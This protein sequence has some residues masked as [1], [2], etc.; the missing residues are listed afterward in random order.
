[1]SANRRGIVLL[2]VCTAVS[3]AML[4]AHTARDAAPPRFDRL[5]PV[6]ALPGTDQ[7]VAEKLRDLVNERIGAFI[8]A[9]D[10]ANVAGFYRLRGFAPLW[11]GSGTSS[12][13][14]MAAM[15]Y[16]ATVDREG[17]DPSDYR[18]PEIPAA[19]DPGALA[20][21]EIRFTAAILNY[22]HEAQNGRIAFSHVTAD[23]D[24]ARK[25]V[26]ARAVLLRIAGTENVAAVLASFN[27]PQPAYRALRAR[28]A[29]LRA[30]RREEGANDDRPESA[31]SSRSRLEDIVVANMERWRWMPRDLGSDYVI[32]NIPNFTLSLVHA[33]SSVFRTSVVVGRP[34]MPTPLISA[35]ITSITI[36]PIWNVPPSIAEEEYLPAL[37]RDPDMAK[38]TGLKIERKPDGT[39]HFYQPPGDANVLG[40]IRFNFPN[41][42]LVYQHDTDAPELFGL[43]LRAASHGCMRVENPFRY[44][45]A[46][47]A[48][49]APDEDYSEERLRSLIGDNEVEIALRRSL[50]VHLSYQTAFVDDHGDLVFRPDIYGLDSRTIA[51]LKRSRLAVAVN[52]A[53]R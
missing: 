22:A 39:L 4:R 52:P 51:A 29:E 16:L 23:A 24:Y 40:R 20:E 32:V 6:A 25:V 31:P 11:I 42:F 19:G 9:P 49:V 5:A 26:N 21:I 37:A 36:N 12:S 44:A 27:P 30:G 18:T 10:R 45:A 41:K 47:L 14:A 50:P 35:A 1:M 33:G 13:R 8:A 28:L 43:D 2:F 15:D 7:A 34:D 17:L 38:H 53:A 46:L 3:L 48:I